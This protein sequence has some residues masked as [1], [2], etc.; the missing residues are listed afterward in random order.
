VYE[1]TVDLKEGAQK[2]FSF[3]LNCTFSDYNKSAALSAR[4]RISFLFEIL[5]GF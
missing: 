5:F 2:S 1:R 3:V 4:E